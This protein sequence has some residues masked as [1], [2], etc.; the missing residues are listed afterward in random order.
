MAKA[1][2]DLLLRA[3]PCR[4]VSRLTHQPLRS[5]CASAAE[6]P[7]RASWSVSSLVRPPLL[8]AAGA[9]LPHPL[10]T[11]GELQRVATLACL[12]LV[13]P[14]RA[15][16][17]AARAEAG[18]SK[19]CARTPA[20][21]CAG[22]LKCTHS[23][24]ELYHPLSRGKPTAPRPPPPMPRWPI[25][26]AS[27]P[28]SARSTRP[29]SSP[30]TPHWTGEAGEEVKVTGA[31]WS[32]RRTSRGV[33]AWNRRGVIRRARQSALGHAAWVRQGRRRRVASS[34]PLEP[35]SS[36]SESSTS[37]L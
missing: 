26:C 15:S 14:R 3:G 27:W 9:H 30:C 12:S 5:L 23:F 22:T 21:T 32:S 28:G 33:P 35:S 13:S 16:R 29:A 25:S 17:E 24:F 11:A 20:R 34:R 4:L 1:A 19:R 6:P 2:L 31:R 8:D 37:R 18:R 36:L 10:L 7:P